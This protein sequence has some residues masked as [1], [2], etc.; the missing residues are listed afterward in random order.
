MDTMTSTKVVAGFCG[1]FLVFLLG[2]W[3]AEEIY[4]VGGHGEAAYVIDTGADEAASDEPEVDFAEIM[5]SADASKGANV[6]KKCQACHK[7]EAGANS[8]G[9]SLHAVVGR[10]VASEPGFGYSAAMQAV[11]G[12]WTPEH[13][14]AFL[15][16]PSAEVPGTAMGFA[17]LRKIEDRANLIAYLETLNN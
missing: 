14:N 2:K 3:V 13:L 5:A 9:P 17:G 15:T 16:K 1:A 4:H 12:T 11:E 7:I 6:F 8:T 10:D